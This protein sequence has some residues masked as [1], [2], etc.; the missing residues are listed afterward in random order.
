MEE[1]S[2]N[3]YSKMLL[4]MWIHR[5]QIALIIYISVI[6]LLIYVKPSM[7]FTADGNVKT[8]STQQS[9]ESSLFSPIIVFPFLALLSYYL[10]IWMELMS[11]Q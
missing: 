11:I 1:V 3:F 5:W 6:S 10:G 2:F 8:W 9:E 7:M 4:E